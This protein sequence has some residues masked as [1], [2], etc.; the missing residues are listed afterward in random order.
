M[1]TFGTDGRVDVAVDNGVATVVLDHSRRRNSLTRS[2]CCELVDVMRRLDADAE[3]KVVALR[4]AGD[5]FS[6]GAALDD[7]DSVLFDTSDGAGPVDRLSLADAAIQAVR[8]PT[9]ALVRGVCMGGAWQIAA[10][11]DLLVAADD[12]RLAITPAKLGILYPRAG[13]ERLA[14]RVGVDRAKWL[15]FSAEEIEPQKAQAWGLVTDL[16]PA[17]EFEARAEELLRTIASRSQYSTVT[18]KRLMGAR[19]AAADTAWTEEWA[20]FPGNEDL[21]AGRKAFMAK[22]APA[23]GWRPDNA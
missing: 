4:G 13:L 23:F 22:R 9:V 8:K 1:N 12:V 17:G 7:L 20:A 18:M 15:L 6:A 11:C 19:G 21:A 3:V 5:D 16:L 2:M 14:D 10:A